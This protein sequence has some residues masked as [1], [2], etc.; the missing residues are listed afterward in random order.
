MS[1]ILGLNF[2]SVVLL[3]RIS[4]VD[5]RLIL[6]LFLGKLLACLKYLSAIQKVRDKIFLLAIFPALTVWSPN[7]Y[8]RLILVLFL[9]KLLACLKYLSAIQEAS[10]ETFLLAILSCFDRLVPEF[11]LSCVFCFFCLVASLLFVIL[12]GY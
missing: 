10:D 7:S 11:V 3:H 9:G 2:L 8:F 4:V 1:R 6:L 12:I 5:F